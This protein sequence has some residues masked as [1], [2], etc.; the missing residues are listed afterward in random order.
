MKKDE[1]IIFPSIVTSFGVQNLSSLAT[2]GEFRTESPGL[3]L[4][5]LTV[6][7]RTSGTNFRVYR[8]SIHHLLDVYVS[9]V[10]RLQRSSSGSVVLFLDRDDQITVKPD[11]SVYNHFRIYSRIVALP[12]ATCL[13]I[14]KI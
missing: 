4:I 5:T 12:K 3:Y 11:K 6:M 8:N 10:Y 2:I 1:P 7:V 9:D 13:T 14:V